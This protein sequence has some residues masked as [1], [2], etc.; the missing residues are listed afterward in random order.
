M[1]AEG[2]RT[3]SLQGK[4]RCKLDCWCRCNACAGP[5]PYVPASPCNLWTSR[6]APLQHV[7][8]ELDARWRDE[9]GPFAGRLPAA[10]T[11]TAPLRSHL[12]AGMLR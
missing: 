2:R 8:N 12:F 6:C 5:A 4:Q 7:L 3:C 9:D 1:Q 11:K 10:D